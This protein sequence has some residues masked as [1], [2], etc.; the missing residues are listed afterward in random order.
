MKTVNMKT[1]T[2]S[3]VGEDGKPETKDQYPWGFASRWIMNL[4]NVSA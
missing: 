3:F 4:C 1:G 2:D